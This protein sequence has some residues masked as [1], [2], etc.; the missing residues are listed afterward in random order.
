M[1]VFGRDR[2]WRFDPTSVRWSVYN[3][4]PPPPTARI[5]E[6]ASDFAFATGEDLWF[7]VENGVVRYDGKTWLHYTAADGL[8]DGHVS[9]VLEGR[10]SHIWVA[11]QHLGQSGAARF[12]GAT[13]RVFSNKDGLVGENIHTGFVADNGDVWF[14]TKFGVQQGSAQGVMRFNGESWTVY[15][16]EDGLIH[17]MI[18]DIV[19]TPDGAVWFATLRGLSR[20]DGQTWTSFTPA[21]GGARSQKISSLG[22]DQRGVLW[23]GHGE[24]G[25]GV[26]S[27]DGESWTRHT[28]GFGLVNRSVW[29]IY[30]ARN[31]V[32]WFG[33]NGGLARFDGSIWSGFLPDELPLPP[34]TAIHGITESIDG[35]LW[36]R[37]FGSGV[38]RMKPD[39]TPPDTALEPVGKEVSS[40]GNLLVKWTGGDLWNETELEDLRYQWRL[41]G[42]VW[43]PA[44]ERTEITLTGLS[45]GEH[46]FEVRSVDKYS[47]VDPSPA[48]QAFV[49]EA[50]WWRNPV[51]AGPG[52]LLI[53]FAVFQ[54]AR[55]V[56][57]DRRLQESVDALSAANHELFEVNQALQRDRAVERLRA[58][59]QSMDQAEDFERVLS[60]LTTDLREVGLAFQ[61]CEIDVL[62]EPVMQPT[63][64]YFEANGFNYSTYRLDPEGNVTSESYSTP[65][66]FPTFTLETIERFI[67]GEPWQ[68]KSEEMSVIEVPAGGY[69]RLRL[70]APNRERFLDDEVATL[71]QFAD[72]VA[73]GYARY[74]DIRE[75]QTQT[76]RKSAFLASMSHELRT[77]M[78]AIKG[79]ANLVLRRDDTLTDRSR[80]NIGKIDQ[81]SDHLLA[82]INDLLDLSKI[83][84]GSMDVRASSFNVKELIESSCDTVSPLVKEGVELRQ[85]IT[86]DLTANTDQARLQQMV[87][88]LLSN[89]IKFTDSGSVTVSAGTEDGQLV[90]AVSDTGKGIP[91]DELPTIFDEYRQAEGSE[92]SVQ[93]GTGLGLSI[94]KKFAELLGG[95]IG[96]ES[97]VGTGSTFTVQVPVDYRA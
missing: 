45:S 82:M 41:N 77:P 19:Q 66:P 32:L 18:Y 64:D 20:F 17:N 44:S 47:N 63:M 27:F 6:L 40:A 16:T 69:G 37:S 65:A 23:I 29:K 91:A 73:L 43:T 68:G 55:V 83:E 34:A 74:L 89:A 93:K 84:A 7:G 61:S 21:E 86:G 30:A 62:V 3:D 72:A 85:D 76:E 25:E 67:R 31:G 58:E 60:L 14:G 8:I 36:L 95:T 13:W 52:I 35:S 28:V 4:V 33:T 78:N 87:I 90:I 57:R 42:D 26:T 15:T 59:V 92:S 79:F 88:N 71:R 75:I 80:E 70:S 56:R 51:V 94:T 2:V 54:S 10:D 1:W 49:V 5:F 11:G 81:A 50:P 48:L 97:E 12:D 22:V 39:R 24:Q 96:V 53:L 9:T 46:T 38:L